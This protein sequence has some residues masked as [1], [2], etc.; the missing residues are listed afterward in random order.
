MK[1][2][3]QV[4]F[5]VMICSTFF[6]KNISITNSHK[7]PKAID[8]LNKSGYEFSITNS[9]VNT[10]YSEFGSAIF[11]NKLIIVSSKKIGALGNRIDKFTNE[12]FTDLFCVRYRQ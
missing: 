3:L 10:I 1:L 12:P 11:K 6:S 4:I 2:S 5:T 9:N 7:N 8:A